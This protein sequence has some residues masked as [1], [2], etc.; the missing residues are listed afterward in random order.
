MRKSTLFLAFLLV[1]LGL[2]LPGTQGKRIS[3]CEMVKILRRNG[4]EGF[5]G[6]T[7]ADWMCLVKHESDYNTKAYNNNGPSRDYGIFQINSKYWCNDGRTPGSKNACR[8]SCSK[9]QDDNI[10]DDIRCAKMIAR[11]AHGLSPWYGWKNNCRGK[12]LSSFVRGC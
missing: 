2:A 8:I 7:V 9:L 1:F 11:E 3:R 12:N 6:T 10:D 5:E 4:F